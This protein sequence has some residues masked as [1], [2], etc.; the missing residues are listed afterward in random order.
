MPGIESMRGK[1]STLH[2][3]YMVGIALTP[4]GT[5]VVLPLIVIVEG[6]ISMVML[7][8]NSFLLLRVPVFISILVPISI[9]I[10]IGTP[11][12]CA[13]P[14]MSMSIFIFMLHKYS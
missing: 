11:P 5:G 10:F 1:P 2:L 4:A 3:P 7:I 13:D 6:D 9:C 8:G 12:V 14:A